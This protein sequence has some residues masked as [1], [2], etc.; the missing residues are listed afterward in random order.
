MT[1]LNSLQAGLEEVPPGNLTQHNTTSEVRVVAIL[2]AFGQFDPVINRSGYE[3]PNEN[4]TT[5]RHQVHGMEDNAFEPKPIH[6][7]IHNRHF[8]RTNMRRMQRDTYP[9]FKSFGLI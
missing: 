2:F 7:D 6:S 3:M 4:A 9:P 5:H 1:R 8:C